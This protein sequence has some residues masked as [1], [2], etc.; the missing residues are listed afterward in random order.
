MSKT[1]ISGQLAKNKFS[2]QKNSTNANETI[3][4][5]DNNIVV[6]TTKHDTHKYNSSDEI[7]KNIFVEKPMAKILGNQ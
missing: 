3:G 1:G 4:S 5:L 6:I 7:Q 2:F